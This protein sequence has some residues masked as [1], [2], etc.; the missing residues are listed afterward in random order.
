MGGFAEN[1]E[2][3]LANYAE[4]AA[5][6]SSETDI[7]AQEAER[8]ATKIKIA[9]DMSVFVGRRFT[10][11][12]AKRVSHAGTAAEKH[13]QDATRGTCLTRKRVPFIWISP[14]MTQMHSVKISAKEKN[15]IFS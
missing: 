4:K 5:L 8:V 3:F 12:A 13:P 14:G 2:K 10:G 7:N 9:E 6:K 11:C 15:S 1:R